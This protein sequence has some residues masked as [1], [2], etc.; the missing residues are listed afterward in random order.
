[1]VLKDE[2]SDDEHVTECFGLRKCPE[3]V[4]KDTTSAV[5]HRSMCQNAPS[6]PFPY[7]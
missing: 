6:V 3:G 2:V 4:L 5:H 1:M 7:P